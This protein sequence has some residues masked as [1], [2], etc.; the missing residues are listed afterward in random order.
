MYLLRY[1]IL[2]PE[3]CKSYSNNVIVILRLRDSDPAHANFPL[4]VKACLALL[5]FLIAR[6][7]LCN[8]LEVIM[9]MEGLTLTHILK[10][11][12]SVLRKFMAYVQVGTEGSFRRLPLICKLYKFYSTGSDANTIESCPY[13]EYLPSDK[14]D[15]GDLE[16]FDKSWPLRTGEWFDGK[17]PLQCRKIISKL[18]PFSAS[19]PHDG[20]FWQFLR[21]VRSP[22]VFAQR[23]WRRSGEAGDIPR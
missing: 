16:A 10:L 21:K 15:H 18:M 5:D 7:P 6:F 11:D 3:E 9:D 13:T 19:F 22:T 23:I 4:E 2:M 20:G 12:L 1:F 14:S 8:G 17:L